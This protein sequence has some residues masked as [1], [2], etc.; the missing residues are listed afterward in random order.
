MTQTSENCQAVDCDIFD[1]H[2]HIDERYEYMSDR[3]L[4]LEILRRMDE[5]K[6]QVSTIVDQV[7]PAVEM[8]SNHPMFKMLGGKR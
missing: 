2:T 7:S 3:D 4:L 8:I 5:V 1:T 6:E